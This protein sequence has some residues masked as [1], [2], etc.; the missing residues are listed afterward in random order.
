MERLEHVCRI[1][2]MQPSSDTRKRVRQAMCDK[3]YVR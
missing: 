2:S 1:L 3:P